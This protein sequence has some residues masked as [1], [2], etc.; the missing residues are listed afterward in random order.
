[1]V[2]GGRESSCCLQVVVGEVG[3]EEEEG[4]LVEVVIIITG[5]GP[6]RQTDQRGVG[7]AGA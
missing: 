3:E 5:Q 7:G 1:V 6:F 4:E 2:R